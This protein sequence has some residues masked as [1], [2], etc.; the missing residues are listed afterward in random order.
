MELLRISETMNKVCNVSYS[1]SNKEK[2][3]IVQFAFKTSD[4]ELTNKLINEL[5]AAVDEVDSIRIMDKFSVMYDVKPDWIN[6]IENLLVSL[7][8]YR[9]EEQKAMSRL[10][11]VLEAYGMDVSEEKEMQPNSI[12]KEMVL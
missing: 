5:V 7:E 1:F 6:E 3:F 12:S 11:E 2:D 9:I 8:M 4:K 10:I